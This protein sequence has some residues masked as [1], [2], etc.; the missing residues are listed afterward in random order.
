MFLSTGMALGVFFQILIWTGVVKPHEKYMMMDAF[1]VEAAAHPLMNIF[2]VLTG[3]TI[4]I[5]SVFLGFFIVVYLFEKGIAFITVGI[6]LTLGGLGLLYNGVFGP[7]H[8][9]SSY[10]GHRIGFSLLS[11]ILWLPGGLMV[12]SHFRRRN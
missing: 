6:F 1:P 7:I 9:D 3:F 2:M 11:I 10:W 4:M 8:P 5:G 12:W